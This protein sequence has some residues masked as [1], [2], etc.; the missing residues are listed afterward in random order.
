MQTQD[1]LAQELQ[2]SLASALIDDKINSLPDLQPQI[3]YNDY[4]LSLIHI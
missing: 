3:I 2:Q 4:K 1:Y